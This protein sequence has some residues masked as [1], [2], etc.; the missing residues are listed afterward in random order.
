M[1]V[2]NFVF[3][4]KTMTNDLDFES[5]SDQINLEQIKDTNVITHNRA[6]AL[7]G[8]YSHI[9]ACAQFRVIT[10][11]QLVHYQWLKFQ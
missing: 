7:I 1:R 6:H 3:S 11:V 10:L 8:E 4:K 9:S 5:F 2:N